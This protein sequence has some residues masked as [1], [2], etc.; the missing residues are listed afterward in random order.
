MSRSLALVSTTCMLLFLGGMRGAGAQSERRAHEWRYVFGFR[1][2]VLRDDVR[3]FRHRGVEC[4]V[5]AVH[6]EIE[7]DGS[8]LE[9]RAITCADHES[10]LTERG[11]CRIDPD[12]RIRV[13]SP[14]SVVVSRADWPR[15]LRVGAA[16]VPSELP[17]PDR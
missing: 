2:G 5:S 17:L 12:G 14:A 1:Q 15:P 13:H 6:I 11:F 3:V 8:R 4:T 9:Q 7:S 10:E 16:C